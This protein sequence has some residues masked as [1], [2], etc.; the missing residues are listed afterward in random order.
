MLCRKMKV[1]KKKDKWCHDVIAYLETLYNDLCFSV[2]Y[3][4]TDANDDEC[5]CLVITIQ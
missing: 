1:V 4:Y 3:E 2:S 5:P